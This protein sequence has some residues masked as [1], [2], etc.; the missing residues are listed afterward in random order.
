MIHVF[1]VGLL[2]TKTRISQGCRYGY[3]TSPQAEGWIPQ[4]YFLC[5]SSGR[6]TT[7]ITHDTFLWEFR[8]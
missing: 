1:T 3:L 6:F 5:G 2:L 7:R 8:E 4:F